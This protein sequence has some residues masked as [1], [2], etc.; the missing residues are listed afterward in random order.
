MWSRVTELSGVDGRCCHLLDIRGGAEL[1]GLQGQRVEDGLFG[2]DVVWEVP[3]HVMD[4]TNRRVDILARGADKRFEGTEVINEPRRMD[5]KT[6]IH[7]G[8][9]QTA[10]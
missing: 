10:D 1:R 4:L 8:T 2:G 6:S 3:L 7:L 9:S 5:R